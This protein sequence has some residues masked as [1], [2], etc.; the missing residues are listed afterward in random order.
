MALA[1]QKLKLRH[2]EF[3]ARMN[4]NINPLAKQ[5]A[6]ILPMSDVRILHYHNALHSDGLR[7]AMGYLERLPPDRFELI[8]K[9]LPFTANASYLARARKK[10]LN[11][12]RQKRVDRFKAQ[13]ILY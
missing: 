4:F 2:S 6:D 9:Y 13:A 3:S 8:R 5:N 12:A 1:V 7:W 11:L 10:F